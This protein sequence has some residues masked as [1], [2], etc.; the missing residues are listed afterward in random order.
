SRPLP[1]FPTRRSSD[2]FRPEWA[3]A[4][5]PAPD[6]GVALPADA[7]RT[8]Q[9]G[10]FDARLAV[11]RAVRAADAAR[12]R[13]WVEAAWTGEKSEQR[14]ELLEAF[15]AGLA[16]ADEAVLEGALAD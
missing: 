11:L 15:A 1:A 4:V 3:W 14:A 13:A 10:Q 2:L 8:W 5:G 16:P 9:E 12:A 7:E 6:A